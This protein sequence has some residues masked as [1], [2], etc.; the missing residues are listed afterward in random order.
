MAR[1]VIE[2]SLW[3]QAMAEELLGASK[4]KLDHLVVE[5]L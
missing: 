4:S 3:V 5:L 1:V 2:G